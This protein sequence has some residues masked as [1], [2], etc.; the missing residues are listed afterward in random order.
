[1]E[2]QHPDASLLLRAYAQGI[3]PMADPRTR[4]I[5]YYSP[6][7]RAV[8]PLDDFHV[9]KSLARVARRGVFELRSDTAFERVIR[10]CA[11]PRPD[12]RETWLDERLIAPYLELHRAGFAHSVEAWREGELVGGLYGVHLGAAFFG[13]S[14]F[15]RPESG[16][17]D[18]SK[19]CLVELVERL[20]AGGFRLLDTQFKTAHLARFG[21]VEI[22]RKRYLALL[23]RALAQ[24]ASWPGAA[25]PAPARTRSASPSRR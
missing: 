25:S 8:L 6:D 23:E 12:R 13:E 24:P 21:C 18:A 2:L 17:R 15:S 3:F 4:R 11:E 1:V 5:D 20:R 22:P 7:P 14:M 19:L 16:G 9:P 10:A